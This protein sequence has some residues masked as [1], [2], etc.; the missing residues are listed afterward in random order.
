M[1]KVI[2]EMEGPG[3]KVQEGGIDRRRR[4]LLCVMSA[5]AGASLYVSLVR[6]RRVIRN[7]RRT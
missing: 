6:A 4:G 5:G 7:A 3:S 1:G 2:R